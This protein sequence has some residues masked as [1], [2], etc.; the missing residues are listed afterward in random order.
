[1]NDDYA[2]KLCLELVP[3]FGPMVEDQGKESATHGSH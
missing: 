2:N 3:N 1:M